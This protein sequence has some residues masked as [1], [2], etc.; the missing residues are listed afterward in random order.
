V[1]IGL[2]TSE[3]DRLGQFAEDGLDAFFGKPWVVTW[4][5][6]ACSLTATLS[7]FGVSGSDVP[8]VA[9]FAKGAGRTVDITLLSHHFLIE[10]AD[11]VFGGVQTDPQPGM[12]FSDPSG[13]GSLVFVSAPEGERRC[14]DRHDPEGVRL[15]VHTKA[16]R[17]PTAQAPGPLQRRRA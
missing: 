9:T 15:V 4:N 16:Q 10:A 17:V 8:N 11:L 6:Q 3:F 7:S 5:G 12:Q 1:S 13:S 14:F 2:D